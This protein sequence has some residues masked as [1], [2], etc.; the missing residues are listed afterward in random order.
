MAYGLKMDIVVDPSDLDRIGKALAD[1]LSDKS[2]ESWLSTSARDY[3]KTRLADR[4]SSG[5]DDVVGIWAELKPETQAIRQA[6]GYGPDRPIN[7]R[8]GDMESF[9]M[10]SPG[11][12]TGSGDIDWDF[13]GPAISSDI[14]EK[15]QTAQYGSPNPHT[16]PR[17]VLGINAVD[18]EFLTDDLGLYLMGRL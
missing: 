13:P 18:A 6:L 5:G 16:V 1:A 15:L 10:G 9:L 2:L 12:I 11:V 14:E 17:P 3:I 7:I 8:T 4:F